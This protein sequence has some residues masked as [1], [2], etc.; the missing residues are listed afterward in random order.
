MT[1]PAT[2]VP[3]SLSH[4]MAL[5]SIALVAGALVAICGVGNS[6]RKS[7]AVALGLAS[8]LMLNDG[9]WFAS[10]TVG[11]RFMVGEH[12]PLHLC[13][14]TLIFVIVA[15][16]TRRQFFYEFAFFYGLGGTLQALLT[17]DLQADFPTHPFVKFFV[18]HG[19]IIVGIVF[20]SL[21]FAMRPS[22]GC[23]PRMI[24]AGTVYMAAVGCFDWLTGSNYG[25]LCHKPQ[26]ASLFDVLGPWPWYLVS[27]WFLGVVLILVFYAPFFF[28]RWWKSR[29]SA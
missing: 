15:L 5:L 27:V 25:Y 18:S 4:L 29:K 8:F 26:G 6:G 13:D 20:L 3:F 16:V 1:Q 10:Q 7:R 23:V 14:V 12:L 28:S 11:A 19:G 17:P 21:V 9:A 22:R 24:L 2:F